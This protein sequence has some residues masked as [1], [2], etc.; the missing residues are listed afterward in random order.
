VTIINTLLTIQM[1]IFM[2]ILLS[3]IAV[4]ASFE[5]QKGDQ[6]NRLFAVF[7][8]LTIVQ[9]ILEILSVVLN[10]S[11]YSH[12]IV[13][14]KTVDTLGFSLTPAVPI[15][16]AFYTYKRTNPCKKIPIHYWLAAP[17]AVNTL[18]S[19]GSY[20]YHWIF[21]ITGENL[22]VRG[23]LFLVSPLTSY[24]YYAIHLIVVYRNRKKVNQE[25][26]IGLGCLTLIP[27]VLSVVQ[28]YYFIYLTIWNS[29]AI[30]VTIN[31]IIITRSRAKSDPL[32]GLGNRTAYDE[33]LSRISGKS[34]IALSVINIDMDGFK[35]INDLFGHKEGDQALKSFA[36]QLKEV[37]DGSGVIIRL[38]GDEFLVFLNMR[39]RILL[40]QHI[41]KLNDR[42]Q[43]YNESSNKPYRIQFSYGIAIFDDSYANIHEFIQ[44]SDKLM[45][46]EKRKKKHQR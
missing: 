21:C 13:L 37:F 22:Y 18:L 8:Y 30:A 44:H 2:L 19:L 4:Y 5:Y 29:V 26:L 14:H 38:G 42:I 24:F 11:N 10:S 12:F 20:R 7:I 6:A 34:N 32:T 31:Y 15:V 27:A 40:E 3:G 33:Y 1:N 16:A 46:E 17:L 23:P 25:E 39:N 36:G 41:K 45:Y 43:A 35:S 9:L 28:L